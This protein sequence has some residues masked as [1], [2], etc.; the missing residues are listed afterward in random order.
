MMNIAAIEERE[1][2]ENAVDHVAVRGVNLSEKCGVF[3]V[4]KFG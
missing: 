3:R 4:D 1:M 2:D